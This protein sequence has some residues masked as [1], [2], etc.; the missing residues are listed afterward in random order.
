[1]AKSKRRKV[2]L[3]VVRE[4]NGRIS[5]SGEAKELPAVA[6]KRLRNAALAGMADARWSTE[7]GRLYLSEKIKEHMFIAGERWAET[8]KRYDQAVAAPSPTPRSANLE[9]GAQAHDP[10]PDSEAGAQI[11]QHDQLIIAAFNKAHKA[12][13]EAGKLAE[14]VVRA[15][16]ERDEFIAEY[17]LPHLVNGL[18]AL[19]AHWR[20]TPGGRDV[21]RAS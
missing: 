1:M 11:I 14:K 7:L 5:R 18:T 8:A 15:L 4:K 17:E 10:D 21:K 13:V 2:R 6:I 9:R 16:C 19:A 12:L 3:V 20:L